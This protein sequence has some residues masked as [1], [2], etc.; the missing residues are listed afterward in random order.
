MCIFW[1]NDNKFALFVVHNLVTYVVRKCLILCSCFC[2]NIITR[3]ITSLN[4]HV[5]FWYINS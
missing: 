5:Y 4:M 1:Q 2:D 3:D